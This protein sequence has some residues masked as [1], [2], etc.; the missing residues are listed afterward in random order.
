MDKSI[1]MVYFVMTVAFRIQQEPIQNLPSL[2]LA[3]L[4]S[5]SEFLLFFF[6]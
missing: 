4:C 2:H 1:Q 5:L 3:A 6:E